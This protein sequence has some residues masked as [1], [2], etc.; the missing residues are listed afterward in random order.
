[1]RKCAYVVA[2]LALL[3]VFVRAEAA[4]QN[5]QREVAGT[6]VGLEVGTA[7][8]AAAINVVYAPLRLV[9]TSIMAGVGG[10][11]GWL[12][13]GDTLSAH[14]IWDNT[15]GP[16]FITPDILER[17]GHRRRHAQRQERRNARHTEHSQAPQSAALR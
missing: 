15:D 12:N 2:V 11:I 10:T 5:P 3:C 14:A 6:S 13:G 4:E 1:M 9:F 16:P 17:H 8:G 7:I